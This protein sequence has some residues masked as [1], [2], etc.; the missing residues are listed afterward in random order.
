MTIPTLETERLRLRGHYPADL[1][2]FLAMWQEPAFYRYLAG[3]PLP[4]EDVWTKMLRHA[5]VW[6]LCGYG[7]WAVE[8]KATGQFIGNV[9]FGEWQR[10]LEPSIKGYPEIGWVLAPRA[11]GRGYAAEAARAVLAWG[12]AHF[13]QKRTVCL[14]DEDNAPS[15]RLAAKCG[16]R[17]F[18]RTAYKAHPI[19]LL[20]RFAA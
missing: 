7:Y 17:E 15:L 10:A 20:E 12:D 8:E 16:Y 4:E 11:H 14:I 5:G 1:V 18:S 3:Q 9:G 6:A 2:P 19:V 13:A